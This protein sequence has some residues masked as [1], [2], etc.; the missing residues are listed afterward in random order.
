[1]Q[2]ADFAVWQ[3]EWLKEEVLEAQLAYWRGGWPARPPCWSSRRTAPRP[4]PQSY[5]GAVRRVRG[6]RPAAARLREAA[7]REGATLFMVL[8]AAFDLLIHRLSGRDDVVVG[9]PIAGR[10][11]GEVEGLIGFFVN[12]M[13]LRVDLSGDPTVPRAGGRVREATLEAYAHQDL[14]FER[15]VEE[16]QPERTLSRNPLFQVAF[17]LQNVAMDPVDLPGLSAGAGGR[18]QRDQQVRHVPGDAARRAAASARAWSTPPS[19]GSRRRAERMVAPLP[20]PAGVLPR[21]TPT[22]APSRA[23]LAGRGRAPTLLAEA[24]NRTASDYPRDLHPT[25]SS[26]RARRRAPKRPPRSLERRGDDVRRAARPLLPPRQPPR[27]PGGDAPTSRWRC[28][29]SARRS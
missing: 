8:L 12:T 3:R 19:C 24:W 5:R 4:A 13:A 27:A 29:A 15:V 16:L 20:A 22:P 18:G 28:C 17:A 1:V 26:R 6:P 2:Y 23:E 7:R 10:V 14:P 9:S 25:P 11:R 21:P